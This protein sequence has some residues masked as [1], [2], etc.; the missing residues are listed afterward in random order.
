MEEATVSRLL[1]KLE[2]AKAVFYDTLV[3]IGDIGGMPYI[4]I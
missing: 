1:R 2:Q 4:G 3:A